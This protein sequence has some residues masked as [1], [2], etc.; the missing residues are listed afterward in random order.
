MPFTRLFGAVADGPFRPPH[1]GVGSDETALEA[2]GRK[3]A[4][5]ELGNRGIQRV[6]VTTGRLQRLARGI[7]S[8]ESARDRPT[9]VGWPRERTEG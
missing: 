6:L 2:L 7:F 5:L 8:E 1:A 3:G 4:S 9:Q